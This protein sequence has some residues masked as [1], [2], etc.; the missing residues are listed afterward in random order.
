M[1]I[2][3]PKYLDLS[4]YSEQF[5]QAQPFPHLALE[6]FLSPDFFL[7]L[8]DEFKK[9]KLNSSGKNFNS[10]VEK[11]KWISLNSSL[12]HQIKY[13]T[14]VLQTEDWIK[15]LIECVKIN[16]LI[17]T[18]TGNTN[19]ANYHTMSPNGIL[20]PHV[21]HSSEP[22]T[23]IPHVLNLLIYLT[24]GWKDKYGGATLLFDKN[25]KNVVKRIS[26]KPNRAIVFLHTPYSFHGVERISADSPHLRR[27]IYI[28]YYCTNKN[29]FCDF[30]LNFDKNW[31]FH[32]T[33][34]KLGNPF[35]YLKLEN[36]IYTK[37]LIQYHLNRLTS[38]S[39]FHF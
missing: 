36:K 27:S 28:D 5:F 17:T 6:N 33:T 24:D 8:Q 31:F 30:I 10:I 12:P 18:D 29:P 2:L 3:N 25:G 32:G 37:S 4:Q 13:I 26:Y 16:D 20:G 14:D 38:N 11:N 19:L 9:S 1:S 22:N 15:N 21:D 35:D 7:T 23:G 39:H 34:F